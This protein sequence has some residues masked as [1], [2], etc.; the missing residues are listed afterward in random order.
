MNVIFFVIFRSFVINRYQS[1][2]IFGDNDKFPLGLYYDLMVS[3][4]YVSNCIKDSV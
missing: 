2:I 1:Y 4:Q 3:A